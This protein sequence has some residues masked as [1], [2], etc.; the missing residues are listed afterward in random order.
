MHNHD[1]Q[2]P[3]TRYEQPHGRK[4]DEYFSEVDFVLRVQENQLVDSMRRIR[5]TVH[6]TPNATSSTAATTNAR[7]ASTTSIVFSV[8][9]T[10]YVS[11]STHHKCSKA[12][13]DKYL[14]FQS[15]RSWIP[16][17]PTTIAQINPI[18]DV[19]KN[20]GLRS[21][22]EVSSAVPGYNPGSR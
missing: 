16:S 21:G 15:S 10:P 18:K 3:R 14:L 4:P 17:T 5:L 8:P 9:S 13:L 11:P 7:I 20:T 2:L 22:R 1:H 19:V 6:P 12:G